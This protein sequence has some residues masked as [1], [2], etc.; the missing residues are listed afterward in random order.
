MIL[1]KLQ[2]L[3]ITES[4]MLMNNMKVLNIEVWK[5]VYTEHHSEPHIETLIGINHY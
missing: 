3:T 2:T 1:Q 5:V 4:N